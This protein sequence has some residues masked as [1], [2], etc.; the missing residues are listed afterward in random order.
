MFKIIGKKSENWWC[1]DI[2]DCDEDG[3]LKTIVGFSNKSII[4]T[5]CS[6][7]TFWIKIT[8]RKFTYNHK[9]FVVKSLRWVVWERIFEKVFKTVFIKV[10]ILIVK[11]LENFVKVIERNKTQ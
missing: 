8:T 7:L 10:K 11:C 6:A 4:K 2:R 3:I 5:Y 9:N 1:F